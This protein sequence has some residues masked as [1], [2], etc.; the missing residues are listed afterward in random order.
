ML[1]DTPTELIVDGLEGTDE[2]VNDLACMFQ[3][4]V[5]SDEYEDQSRFA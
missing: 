4:N 3:L 1:E 2:F 5:K